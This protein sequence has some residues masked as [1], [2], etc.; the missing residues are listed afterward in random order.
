MAKGNWINWVVGGVAAVAIALS[1]GALAKISSMETTKDIGFTNYGVGVIESDGSFDETVKQAVVSKYITTEG[2]T[3]TVEEDAP[4]TVE[5]HFYNEDRE[6]L[7]SLEL[8][9]EFT[10]ESTM[11]EGAEYVRVEITPTEDEDGVSIFELPGYVS[12]V[13]VVVAK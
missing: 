3:V 4:V 6:Y 8:V 12:H 10:S 1:A 7:S 11:P 13:D 2:L 5:L 9:E